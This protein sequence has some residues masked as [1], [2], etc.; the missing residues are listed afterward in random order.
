MIPD[1][2]CIL[3]W[4]NSHIEADG[5]VK[6]CC[7]SVD[8]FVVGDLRSDK[9][10]EIINSD[11]FKNMRLQFINGEKP[12]ACRSCFKLEG[13]GQT[14]LRKSSNEKYKSI[15]QEKIKYTEEGGAIH[16]GTL[17]SLDLRFSNLCNFKCR[18]CYEGASTAWYKDSNLL[19]GRN[20]FKEI[21][22]PT[23]SKD[24]MWDLLDGA[25]PSLSEIYILGG[26]PLL[27]PDHYIFLKKLIAKN[28]MDIHLRYSTNLSVLALGNDSVFDYW[29][30]FNKVTL[31]L[32]YDGVGKQGEFIRKGMSWAK[33]VENHRLIQEKNIDFI[34]TPTISV[35]NVFHLVDLIRFL[36]EEKM[37]ISGEQIGIN[38]LEQPSFFNIR[39]LNSTERES[40]KVKYFNFIQNEMSSMS[41]ILKEIIIDQ[42][43][44][45]IQ[46]LSLEGDEEADVNE[47]QKFIVQNTRLNKLRSENMLQLFP[48]LSGFYLEAAQKSKCL[49]T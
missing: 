48:E 2:F 8:E 30:K 28:R 1:N 36:V 14:T 10:E 22:Y 44:R 27:D 6:P 24:E 37:I 13:V 40:L 20:Q 34:I 49:K 15:I 5:R 47:R 26:E 16:Q 11:L 33:T 21:L 23:K 17:L 38:I 9:L 31:S 3:P 4:I 19:L 25:L 41:L 45:V 46:Y 18:T 39:I 35:L 32:S 29:S 43:N 12:A 7:V 42:L